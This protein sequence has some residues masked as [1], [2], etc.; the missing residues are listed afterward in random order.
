MTDFAIYDNGAFVG[1]RDFAE[2]PTV[3]GKPYRKFYAIEKV[4]PAFNAVTQVRSGPVVEEDHVGEIRRYVF[5]VR[6]KTVPELDA[7]KEGALDRYDRLSFDLNFDQENRI[8]VL[9][10]K[11]PVTRA[12]YRAALKAR[13]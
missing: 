10:V 13:L 11:A 5:A 8:R 12:Q 4:D 6:D 1:E 7:E 2:K 3:A 9:E